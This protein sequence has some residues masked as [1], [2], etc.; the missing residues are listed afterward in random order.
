MLDWLEIPDE[1]RRRE[2]ELREPTGRL[3]PAEELMVSGER[4]YYEGEFDL[5][6]DKGCSLRGEIVWT[7]GNH[8][9]LAHNHSPLSVLE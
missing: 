4:L 8:L 1:R 5:A 2:G 3:R 7:T 9:R 6:S